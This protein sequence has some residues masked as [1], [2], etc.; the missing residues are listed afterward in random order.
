MIII[1]RLVASLHLH[2]VYNVKIA[3][4][5]NR[6]FHCWLFSI[7]V[8]N[9]VF[10]LSFYLLFCHSSLLTFNIIEYLFERRHSLTFGYFLLSMI[11]PQKAIL[12]LPYALWLIINMFPLTMNRNIWISLPCDWGSR[13]QK[14]DS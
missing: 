6:G 3:C 9:C 5:Q 11:T 4:I 10:L 1:T 13:H 8:T 7:S 2:N 14:H 12:R